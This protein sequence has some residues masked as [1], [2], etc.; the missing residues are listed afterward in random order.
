MEPLAWIHTQP[1][2]LPQLS[3]QEIST[4]AKMMNDQASWDGEKT[5]IITSSFTPDSLSFTADK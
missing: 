5:V 2:E 3:P 1:A 4:H